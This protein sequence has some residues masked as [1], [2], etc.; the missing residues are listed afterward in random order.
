MMTTCPATTA[1]ALSD[2][3]DAH[4]LHRFVHDGAH[5]A[6]ELLVWRHRRLV[7]GVCR[8]V[9][10]HAHDAE[11]AAQAT[12]L[13][14]ARRASDVREVNVAGWLARVAYRCAIRV[15]TSQQSQR[16]GD[17]STVPAPE[18][19]TRDPDLN[20]VLDE[21]LNRLPD[22][23]R[24]PVVLCYLHGKTYDQAAGELNCPVGTLCGWLTRAKAML[25]RRLT[26]RGL[27]LSVSGLTVYLE[28]VRSQA[29]ATDD[30]IRSITAAA[31]AFAGGDVIPGRAAA[32]ANGVLQMM[33]WKSKMFPAML[34]TLTLLLGLTAAAVPPDPPNPPVAVKPTETKT[35]DAD[36][37]QGEWLF[38]AASMGKSD[39]LGMVWTTKLTVAG[40]AI[41][42]EGFLGLK[43]SLKGN[44][45]L[46]PTANPKR[47]D[48]QLEELDL[49]QVGGPMKIPAGSYLGIYELV[50][51]RLRLRFNREAGGKR[52]ASFDDTGE[53]VC[54]ASLVKAPTSFTAFP[55]EIQVKVI[56]LDGKPASGAIVASRILRPPPIETYGSDGARI[57]PSK[58]TEEQRKEQETRS[59][60]PEG[61][62]EEEPGGWRAINGRRTSSEGI[63]K[64]RYEDCSS[65]IVVRDPASRGMRIVPVSP[66]SL[67]GGQVTV[68]LRPV[69]R[70]LA[71]ATCAGMT[72]AEREKQDLDL[73]FTTSI[74]MP[75]GRDFAGMYS[76]SGELE[77]PLPPGDYVLDVIGGSY[78]GRKSTKFTV[79]A[80]QSEYRVPPVVLPPTGLQAWIGKPAPELTDVVAWKGQPVK[81]ADLKGKVVLLHFWGYWCGGCIQDMP[82]LMEL[83]DTFKDKGLVI[84]GIHLDGEGEIDSAKALDEKLALYKKD[85]WKGKDIPF[86]VALTSGKRASED[87]NA[88]RG[89]LAQKFGI[90]GYPHTL[91]IDRDGK[92]VGDGLNTQDATKA[93][94]RIEYLL[95]VDKK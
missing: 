1:Q 24:V 48:L 81:L 25:R 62:I 47:F 15:R 76:R 33:T 20:T 90:R 85:L 92:I 73:I 49:A 36:H 61:W 38:D 32:V 18:P 43:P 19:P 3:T 13:I 22:K 31:V 80:N 45:R 77:Y 9:T 67:I 63:A 71:T 7:F 89:P 91:I 46:D 83:H 35:S 14:L 2:V 55:K 16:S 54:G 70:V 29:L 51:G 12:F 42:M 60:L 6:F 30:A 58:L 41:T 79:P 78:Y 87:E 56:G 44:I 82:V 37:L 57:E 8:R 50:G 52:P 66:S 75:D 95:K 94:A 88:G 27:T 59:K 23:Y 72:R 74:G 69:C 26:R 40:D 84:V 34:G 64:M 17:L 10:G 65:Q 5:A 86:P 21:E 68:T 11:D 4:L 53:K 93:I 39:I 28:G